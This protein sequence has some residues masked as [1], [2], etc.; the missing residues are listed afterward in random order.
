MKAVVYDKYGPPDGLKLKEVEKP[1][2]KDDQVLIK[3][4][5]V[6]LNSSDWEFLRGSPL[7]TRMWGLLKPKYNILG[8]DV[9]GRVEAVGRN[10]EQFQTGD[11]VFG[12]IMYCWGGFA[13]Y[14]C[15]R[16][17]ALMLKPNSM[18]FEEAA[19][20]P[21]AA[22][23]AL[24]GLRDKGKI[25]PGQ[26]VLINGAGGGAGTFCGAAGQIIRGRGDRRR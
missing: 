13:E 17:D 12:D 16:E 6:S 11:E 24:Q 9:A 19:A 8:S 10:V 1:T 15:A 14:V 23:V 7:Y 20:I 18:T 21:Q 22:T 25:E 5:A 4:Y 3:V 2:P 26:K